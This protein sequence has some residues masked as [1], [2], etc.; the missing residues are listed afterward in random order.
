MTGHMFLDREKGEVTRV[1]GVSHVIK[2][3][4]VYDAER[5]LADVRAMVLNAKAAEGEDR[6]QQ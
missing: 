5:L 1:G 6:S 4:I 3:G 2:S